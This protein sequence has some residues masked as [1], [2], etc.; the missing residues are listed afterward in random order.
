MD[1]DHPFWNSH[2][3]LKSKT[4]KRPVALFG[5][6]RANEFLANYY[7]PRWSQ[8]NPATAWSAFQKLPGGTASD[9]VRRAGDLLDGVVI[10]LRNPG[11]AAIAGSSWAFCSSSEAYF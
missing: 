10:D 5:K 1:L 2:Y 3:T 9:P 6:S 7:I 8:S 11:T 4:A